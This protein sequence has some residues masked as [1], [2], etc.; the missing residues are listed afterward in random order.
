MFKKIF[1]LSA[2]LVSIGYS[3]VVKTTTWKVSNVERNYKNKDFCNKDLSQ[4]DCSKNIKNIKKY[5]I[6]IDTL[7]SQGIKTIEL[8]KISYKTTNTFPNTGK[9]T[10]KV[11]GLIM[12]PNVENP[13][14]VVLYYHPTVFDNSAVP[15]NLSKKNKV[16]YRFNTMYAAIYSANGYIV[17]APDYIGQ[18]DD[19][20]NYHPYVVYPK[21]TVNTAID[22][23]NNVSNIIRKKYNLNDN[24]LNLYSVGYSEGGAYSIWTAK[25]LQSTYNCKGIDKL[26]KLYKY[27]GAVGLDG[28]YDISGTLMNFMTD[29]DNNAK[30][31]IH[32]K[33]VTSM[34]K[35]NLMVDAFMSYLYYGNVGKTISIK[36]IDKDFFNMQCSALPQSKCN[37]ANKHYTLDS[38]FNE[39][40]LPNNGVAL[41][42]FD[43]AMYKKYPNQDSA[44][45]YFIPTGN[46][47]M[48]DLFN[49]KIFDDKELRETAKAADIFDFGKKTRTPIFLFTLKEDSVVTRLNYDKFMKNANAIVDGF[50][51][52]NSKFL[53]KSSNWLTSAFINN[54]LDH[55][56]AEGYANLFAYQYINDLNRIYN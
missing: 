8:D 27:H 7:G 34:I 44:S 23:L 37:I 30:Y 29:N 43:S 54:D 56:T 36:D 13:K 11:S 10:S 41:A 52:D 48:L 20:K 53:T 26:N 31:K 14:G 12:L 46:N 16:S 5:G 3:E 55:V 19:Y 4:E 50:V 38:L 40:S 49:E 25:C 22:L 39:K 42:V 32:S 18:G 6:D 47:S 35:P 17:V 28:A 51:L 1:L 33:L 2:L 21:Q 15:S 24:N 9:I 45:H